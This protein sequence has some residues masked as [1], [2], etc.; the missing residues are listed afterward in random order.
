MDRAVRP[1]FRR[2]AA[3][4]HRDMV[5]R[6]ERYARFDDDVAFSKPLFN[7]AFSDFRPVGDVCPRLRMSRFVFFIAV[8][9]FMQ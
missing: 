6:G 4:F 1:N 3:C 5:G 7:V 2:G 9:M 8:E